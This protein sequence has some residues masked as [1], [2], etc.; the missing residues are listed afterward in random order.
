VA[1][2]VPHAV[3][4]VGDA[5]LRRTL[6]RTLLASGATLDF[7]T[8]W[9][10]FTAD[11]RRPDLVVLDETTR[12][13]TPLAALREV[14]AGGSRLIVLGGSLE[15]ASVV[16]L[17]RGEVDHCI[18]DLATLDETELVVTSSKLFGS[19]IFGL[20][21][22]L[23]WGARISDFEVASYDEKSIALLAIAEA[24]K[25]AGARRSLIARVER[26]ADEL[27]MNALYD[28]PAVHRGREPRVPQTLEECAALAATSALIRYGCDGRYFGVS[29]EDRYGE[30]QKRAILDAFTRARR[31][32]GQ[33][34]VG[35]SAG[36]GLYF[37]LSSAT[38]FCAN[39]AARARTE[40]LCLFDMRQAVSETHAT[41]RSWHVFRREPAPAPGRNGAGAFLGEFLVA[42]GVVSPSQLAAAVALQAKRNRPIGAYAVEHGYLTA[43]RADEI[44]REQRRRD[45]RFGE[46]AIELGYL[47]RTQVDDL[48]TLQEYDRI[49]IGE[50]L[51][52]LGHLTRPVLD[53]EMAVF[54]DRQAPI[55]AAARFRQL[56][57][58]SAEVMESVTDMSQKMLLRL[59]GVP[60]KLAGIEPGGLPAAADQVRAALSITG[61]I[62]LECVISLSP[63]IAARVSR[64]FVGDAEDLADDLVLECT[65]ELINIIC[66]N[67]VGTIDRVGHRVAISPPYDE[68]LPARADEHGII[69][70]LRAPEGT[71]T[72][73]FRDPPA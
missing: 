43:D 9:A 51:L 31:T 61:D 10:S 2:A 73:C 8:S 48:V 41:A 44:N 19:D 6:R 56:A 7:H 11:W 70:E 16:E 68:G 23:S 18:G 40:V 24:A 29:V 54:A 52:E 50:A 20:D 63:S 3:C 66:G 15:E 39:V 17:L 45:L 71:V 60:S 65:K 13:S 58:A 57:A 28:A 59:G 67:A 37:V 35:G 21:K 34:R 22:Y 32:H 69:V 64:H 12:Q 62:A 49:R 47:S 42:R 36:L 53:F 46:L 5:A 4:L 14:A 1:E 33:P 38:L 55:V 30:L 25:R 27:L 26:V 72:I